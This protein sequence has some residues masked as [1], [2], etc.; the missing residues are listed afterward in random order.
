V[1]VVLEIDGRLTAEQERLLAPYRRDRMRDKA[2]L[3][4][5]LGQ[6]VA[7]YLRAKKREL[8]PS[9]RRSYEGTLHKLV[10]DFPDLTVEDFEPPTGTVLLERFLDDRWGDGAPGTY[11]VCLAHVKDFFLFWR[12]RERLHGDPTLAVKR[13]EFRSSRRSLKRLT[14]RRNLGGRGGASDGPLSLLRRPGAQ[15]RG[16]RP[17]P[18]GCETVAPPRGEGAQEAS[19]GREEGGR[20]VRVCACGCGASL[21]GRKPEAR[22]ASDACRSR[23]WKDRTGYSHQDRENGGN[24]AQKRHS[25]LQVSYRK[26]VEILHAELGTPKHAL[27]LALAEALSHRQRERLYER[28]PA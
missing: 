8:T 9:S 6:D 12:L 10:Q 1:S 7:D 21:E 13:A 22:F 25:G 20:A 23:A 28:E 24:G 17:V 15:A 2:F 18:C 26:A 19:R 14:C 5:P 16:L 27:E 11:N 3:L 4:Q